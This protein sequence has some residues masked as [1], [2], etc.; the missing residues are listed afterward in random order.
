VGGGGGGR[1]YSGVNH[2]VVVAFD[3]FT[4]SGTINS[5]GLGINGAQPATWFNLGTTNGLPTGVQ[6]T[7][8]NVNDQRIGDVFNVSL[9]Y[10]PNS[11]ILTEN[12]TDLTLGGVNGTFPGGRGVAN[13]FTQ[14]YSIDI[15]ATLGMPAG[16]VGFTG[17]SGGDRSEKDILNWQF[18]PSFSSRIYKNSYT[19]VAGTDTLNL[20]RDADGTTIDWTVTGDT[21]T[22]FLPINDT[23]GLTITG[24]GGHDV[25]NLDYT[26]GNPLPGL[27]SIKQPQGG[28]PSVNDVTINGLTGANAFSNTA[29]DIN[30][31]KVFLNYGSAANDAA[32]FALVKQYLTNGYN[33]NTWT[34]AAPAGSGSIRSSAAGLSPN[35]FN[36]G[37][38]DST[39]PANVNGTANT[40]EV[41]YTIS[42]DATMD[43]RVNLADVNVVGANFNATPARWDQGSFNYDAFVNLADVNII[44]ANF[45]QVL[46]AGGPAVASAA[47]APAT[48]SDTSTASN[49]SLATTTPSVTIGSSTGSADSS[50]AAVLAGANVTSGNNNNNNPKKPGKKNK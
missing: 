20:K 15:A 47:V 9:T 14:T 31:S 6:Y 43:G 46:P 29:M 4:G 28:V 22:Y 34:G 49:S 24:A 44:G 17:A 25:I 37:Y 30:A 38:S 12:V 13:Q 18:T 36:V 2:S 3:T 5:T 26:T 1:G 16:F 50:A 19:G 48:T 33:G 8:G 21:N 45:N 27:M 11:H 10:D 39:S 7:S 35:L 32:V 42:G 40:I 23:N 41:M